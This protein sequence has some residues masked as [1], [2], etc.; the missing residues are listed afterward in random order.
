M[1]NIDVDLFGVGGR[2]ISRRVVR[3]RGNFC[4][5]KWW[6][7]KYYALSPATHLINLLVRHVTNGV[8]CHLD[9]SMLEHR[10][11]DS[12]LASRG[13]DSLVAAA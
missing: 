7:Q 12:P 10:A 2:D 11:R 8:L 5:S 4:K 1:Q 13:L 3:K 6:I 9:G